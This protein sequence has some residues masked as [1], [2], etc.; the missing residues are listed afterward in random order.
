[1]DMNVR[2][3]VE[4]AINIIKSGGMIILTD[5]E[6]R[7]N[8]GDL[9]FAADFV[10]PEKVNFMATYGRGLICVALSGEKCDTLGLEQMS[11]NNS[12]RFGT[13]FTVSV[14]AKHGVTTGISAYDRAKTIKVLADPLSKKSDLIRPGHIF[15]L[16]A[17]DG[18]V[19]VRPGQTE[20]SVDLARLAGL[21]HAGVI[22]E[23]MN[24]DGTM[25]R[26]NDLEKFAS[27]HSLKILT[28]AD[29]I[30]YRKIN[31]NLIE[32]V[33]SA[34]L[35]TEYGTFKIEGY[36]N[37]A[38]GKEA[39]ALIKGDIDGG[40][41]PL[42]RVHSQCLTGDGFASLRC[43]CGNQLHTAMQ[44]IE[45]EGRGVILYMFQEGRGIG[46]LNKIKAYKLQDEGYD[47]VEANIKLGFLDDERDY[48]FGAQ[49][50]RKLGVSRMRFM[51]NNPRKFS[52]L[53]QYGLEIVERVPIQCGIGGENM[54]YMKTKKDKLCHILD[55]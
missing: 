4:E 18:G 19:L 49:L 43:D 45:H 55:I 30:E 29:L 42:V 2:A 13:A 40:N 52:G 26:M 28:I 24:D 44:M 6:S 46:L 10:T 31:D 12:C 7:E 3:G 32:K 47:T 16:R 22:C 48:S 27:T 11:P 17:K 41:P 36:M 53:E 34:I 33:S 25:A 21:N 20:G 8:E 38:D 15:P 1:M 39:V 50:L 5:D 23:I 51:S 37:K 9:V 14:E 54:K 35:P